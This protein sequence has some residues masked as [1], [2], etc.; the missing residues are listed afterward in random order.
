MC[1]E[2][3]HKLQHPLQLICN[4]R[5]ASFVHFGGSR[6][7]CKSWQWK[8]LNCS[9]GKYAF[10][11][12]LAN[13]ECYTWLL[14]FFLMK[15]GREADRPN[16][17]KAGWDEWLVCLEIPLCASYSGASSAAEV[18]ACHLCWRVGGAAV[19]LASAC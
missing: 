19:W 13:G 6:N 18:D 5:K 8:Q 15:R 14:L 17:M 4:F 16:L 3:V 7:I 9:R 10:H 1:F 2:Q 11:F 12:F